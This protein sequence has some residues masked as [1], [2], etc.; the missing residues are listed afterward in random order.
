MELLYSGDLD[1]SV[2]SESI[3]GKLSK[4]EVKVNAVPNYYMVENVLGNEVNAVTYDIFENVT[5]NEVKTGSTK[6]RILYVRNNHPRIVKGLYVFF[7]RNDNS[8]VSIGV[9]PLRN[10]LAPK[11]PDELTAPGGV[12]FSKPATQK[13]PLD[14]GDLEAGDFRAL[15]LKREIPAGLPV[16]DMFFS[17]AIQN[18]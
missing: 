18:E 9:L 16:Q 13:E 3:G 6:Y 7:T 14:L 2:S 10:M 11:L 1:N 15:Y 12:V 4:Y 8:N 5:G 17:F